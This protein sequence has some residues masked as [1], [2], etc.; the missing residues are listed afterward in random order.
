MACG[1]RFPAHISFENLG[2]L[3]GVARIQR[4]GA[5]GG[6]KLYV[7]SRALRT[8]IKPLYLMQAGSLSGV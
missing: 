5:K 4:K 2:R 6:K 3:T 8:K 1:H 7:L